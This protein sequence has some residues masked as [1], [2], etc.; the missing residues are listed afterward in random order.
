LPFY[1]YVFNKK[2]LLF[3]LFSLL[4]SMYFS[5]IISIAAIYSFLEESIRLIIFRKTILS[6]TY[7]I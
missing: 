4:V 3:L 6:K 2:T 1:Q 5:F 7:E